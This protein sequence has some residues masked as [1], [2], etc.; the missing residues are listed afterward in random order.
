MGGRP[1]R[2]LSPPRTRTGRPRSRRPRLGHHRSID[3]TPLRRHRSAGVRPHWRALVAATGAALLLAGCGGSGFD[4]GG[5][6]GGT[7]TSAPAP[8]RGGGAFGEGASDG[9]VGEPPFAA[10]DGDS[11]GVDVGTA[12]QQA[13]D[14]IRR[15]ELHLQYDDPTAGR[16]RI[17]A[18]IAAA[19][20]YVAT[21]ELYRD[22]TSGS[23]DGYLVARVPAAQ[24][25][26][27][28]DELEAGA[29]LAPVRRVDEEDVTTLTVDLR[30]QIRNLTAYETEL[31]ELLTEVRQGTGEPDHLLRVFDRVQSVRSDIDRLTAQLDRIQDQVALST[32][33]IQLGPTR[34]ASPLAVRDSWA[35]G[36]TIEEAFDATVRALTRIADAAIWVVLTVLPVLAV[37]L[38]LPALLLWWLVRRRP[39]TGP[40][41]TPTD[42]PPAAGPPGTAPYGATPPASPESPQSPVGVAPG[43]ADEEP[44]AGR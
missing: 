18:T 4:A 38:V 29:D 15:A 3:R 24:L 21:A 42:A 44:D 39:G 36:R 41:T 35:P 16:A 17:E 28:L 13:R 10:G 6:G 14:V 27:V 32:I 9:S 22:L 5:A 40:G 33:T 8:G 34:S 25:D 19:G 30:A 43:A 23:L 1:L 31:T 37:I 20:G 7:D 26:A 2:F 12:A 11:G